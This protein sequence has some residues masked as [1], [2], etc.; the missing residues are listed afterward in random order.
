MVIKEILE[1]GSERLKKLSFSDPI[2]ESMYIM[3]RVLKED[4]SFLYT[5]LDKWVSNEEED[6]FFS[7]INRRATGEPMSY[8]FNE[9]EFMGLELFVGKGVLIPRPETEIL[10]EY[11]LDYLDSFKGQESRVLDIGTG[12]GAIALSIANNCKTSEVLGI[13]ISDTALSIARKNLGSLKV[14]NVSFR[15]S[16]LFE[17]INKDEKFSI[18][19]SNPPYIKTS[20]IDG[21]QRDVKNFEPKLALDGGRDGLSFYR[22]IISQSKEFLENRGMVIFEI[23][24]DQG[25]SVKR[26]LKDEDFKN[27][28]ILK[29]LQGLD[30]IV[31]GFKE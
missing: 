22:R 31:L 1:M 28:K 29:D 8:I 7:Y 15:K 9:K 3:S 21:L 20:V 13:D 26:M 18:I 10:V 25:E 14:K 19:V 23:G 4:K 27:I 2:K 30:R 6:K 5:N 24:F 12:T 17:N 11:I 16:D